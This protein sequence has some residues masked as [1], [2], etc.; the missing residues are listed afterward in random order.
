MGLN[1]CSKKNNKKKRRRCDSMVANKNGIIL[2]LA[3]FLGRSNPKIVTKTYH[4]LSS[5]LSLKQQIESY[6]NIKIVK[7]LKKSC[8]FIQ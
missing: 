5:I 6:K 2:F 8:N 4:N 7:S 1:F 3:G